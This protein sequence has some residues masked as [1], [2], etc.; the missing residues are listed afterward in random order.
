[1]VRRLGM[2]FHGAGEVSPFYVCDKLHDEVRWAWT[3]GE[4]CWIC[5][6]V[7]RPAH[8]IVITSTLLTLDDDDT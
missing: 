2:A 8:A 6:A 5:G 7:G 1:M 3:A 4:Y